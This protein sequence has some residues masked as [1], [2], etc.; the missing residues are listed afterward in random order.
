MRFA[1]RARS[2]LHRDV[3]RRT[4]SCERNQTFQA[5]KDFRLL[6]SLIFDNEVY[7]RG[8]RRRKHA[9]LAPFLHRKM[10]VTRGND[11][12]LRN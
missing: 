2:S 6:L 9:Y 4:E 10:C 1:Q 7:E 5:S 3:L 11:A 8:L 12:L